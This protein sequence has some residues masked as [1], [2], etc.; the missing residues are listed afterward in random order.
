MGKNLDKSSRYIAGI[1]DVQSLLQHQPELVIELWVSQK[2]RDGKVEAIISRAKKLDKPLKR[3]S[4]DE[5]ADL[6]PGVRHQGVVAKCSSTAKSTSLE[7]LLSNLSHPPFLL[8]LDGVQDPHNLGACM[9]S[10]DAAGIDAIIVPAD[11]ACAITPTVSRVAA[12]ATH[13][14]PLIEVVNLGRCLESLQQQGIWV[15][16]TSDQASQSIWQSDLTG[17]LALVLGAEGT[18]MRSLTTNR[19]DTLVHIPMQGQVESLNVSVA[20][21][22]VLFEACRQRLAPK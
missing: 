15:I 13:S 3:V 11:N 22:V 10:A 17:P 2:R 5:L 8:V 20:A 16:G 19:C 1:R 12:G 21:G 14:V 4:Q 9:R 7:N 18:G 6:V